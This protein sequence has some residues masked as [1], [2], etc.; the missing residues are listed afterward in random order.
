VTFTPYTHYFDFYSLQ[1]QMEHVIHWALFPFLAYGVYKL[2][3]A[4][5][6]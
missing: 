2:F 6:S 3:R 4:M 5:T 1:S